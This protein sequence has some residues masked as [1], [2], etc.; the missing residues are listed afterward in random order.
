MNAAREDILKIVQE[1]VRGRGG[2]WRGGCGEK[3]K[4]GGESEENEEG[5]RGEGESK[6]RMGGR[7]MV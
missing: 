3:G 4:R 2:R 6:K 5:E 7:G 1:L